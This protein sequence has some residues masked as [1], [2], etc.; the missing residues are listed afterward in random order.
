MTAI[1]NTPRG[2]GVRDQERW[3]PLKS[4]VPHRS[5]GHCWVSPLGTQANAEK[6]RN[7]NRAKAN[8]GV[9]NGQRTQSQSSQSDLLVKPCVKL[10]VTI[11]SG[12][13]NSCK[14]QNDDGICPLPQSKGQTGGH[15]MDTSIKQFKQSNIKS[16]LGVNGSSDVA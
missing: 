15:L 7:A 11:L 3:F 13:R 2:G 4:P 8:V 5:R 10:L 1:S 16:L 9:R 14:V 12:I 6:T